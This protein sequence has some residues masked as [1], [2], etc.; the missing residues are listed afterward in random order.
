MKSRFKKHT[1]TYSFFS[2]IFIIIT[3][4]I[5]CQLT[6]ADE[7]TVDPKNPSLFQ[8]IQ[9][10][11]DIASDHSLIHITPGTYLESLTI[12]K[13]ITIQGVDKLSES[14]N[15]VKRFRHQ[16]LDIETG[17]IPPENKAGLV[18][19]FDDGVDT[20]TEILSHRRFFGST[21]QQQIINIDI[22][23]A[24]E[25]DHINEMSEVVNDILGMIIVT[26]M[27][28]QEE[29]NQQEGLIRGEG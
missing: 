1:N 28:I 26:D 10:A 18:F 4:C 3:I 6:R 11:I 12:D 21:Q 24:D 9:S 8:T 23:I 22:G 25:T 20:L 5:H 27:H 19:L 2:I 29:L 17:R 7:L 15:V 16:T 13:P 14:H